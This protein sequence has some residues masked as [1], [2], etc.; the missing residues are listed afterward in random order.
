MKSFTEIALKLFFLFSI[1]PFLLSEKFYD[2]YDFRLSNKVVDSLFSGPHALG[3]LDNKEINEASGLVSSKIHPFLLYTHNDSGG[4]PVIFMIDTLGSYKGKIHLTGVRNRDWE[5]IAIGPGK[6]Q[7]YIYVGDIGD[8]ESY[9]D[10]IQ[11]YRFPEP[12]VLE[13]EII[14]QPEKITLK[15]PGGPMDAE[16]LMVDPWSGDVFI[17]SKRDTSN[18]LFR[19]PADQLDKGE[20]L[21]E[22]IMKLPITV[23]VGGD[24]SVD[25]KQ[26]AIKNYWVIYYWK[27]EEGE[28]IPDAFK[29]KPQQLPYKPEPQGEAIGFSSDGSRF[30]T[31]SENKFRIT[32]VLYQHLK[33]DAEKYDP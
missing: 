2:K 15:Y 23:A 3:K 22:K 33:L 21:L 1:V 29:R 27:R 10:E 13:E 8:N 4:A 19:A 14:V 26:I 5:D 16:T 12:T 17:L 32:P 6:N 31:L 28:S 20:V 30:Y 9:R 11:L 25:G 7:D 18:T 24:I